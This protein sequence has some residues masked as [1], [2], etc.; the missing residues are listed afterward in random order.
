MYRYLLRFT[1]HGFQLADLKMGLDPSRSPWIAAKFGPDLP[2]EFR[3]GD[4]MKP[5]TGEYINRPLR[6][7]QKYRVFLRAYTSSVS[8][9]FVKI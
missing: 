7:S 4:A 8:P 1:L 3:L 2:K 9:G 6:K 5:G